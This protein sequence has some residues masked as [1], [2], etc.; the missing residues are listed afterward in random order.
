[1]CKC[2]THVR[3]L[4]TSLRG[5]ASRN[6]LNVAS[7][8]SG[9]QPAKRVRWTSVA[10]LDRF[11]FCRVIRDHVRTELNNVSFLLLDSE[12]IHTRVWGWGIRTLV[13]LIVLYYQLCVD[14]FFFVIYL[15]WTSWTGWTR[16][17]IKIYEAELFFGKSFHIHKIVH[18]RISRN[19]NRECYISFL[20]K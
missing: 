6:G 19:N 14:T 9:E 15:S 10:A 1:M 12:S 5:G 8:R 16:W 3:R 7:R 20:I 11:G 2:A 13:N 17:T 18:V 4:M